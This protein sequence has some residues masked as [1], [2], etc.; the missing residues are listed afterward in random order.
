MSQVAACDPGGRFGMMV[1]TVSK[2]PQ[3]QGKL[4]EL[5]LELMDSLGCS[6]NVTRGK[7]KFWIMQNFPGLPGFEMMDMGED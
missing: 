6:N 7:E 5:S 3:V 4:S 1:Q 2:F